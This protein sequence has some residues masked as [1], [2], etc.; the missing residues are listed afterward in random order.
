MKH[1]MAAKKAIKKLKECQNV[2]NTEDAH[3][4]ADQVLCNLLIYLGYK[5]VVKEWRQV[6]K[7]YE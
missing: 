5:D 3:W 4:D 7:W 2:H 6:E 1:K